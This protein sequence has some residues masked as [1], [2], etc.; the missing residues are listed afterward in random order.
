VADALTAPPSLAQVQAEAS[1]RELLVRPTERETRRRDYEW[2]ATVERQQRLQALAPGCG[3]AWQ[4]SRGCKLPVIP[5]D[6]VSLVPV[7]EAI[8]DPMEVLDYWS[9]PPNLAHAVGIRLG[10]H[11]GGAMAL[12]GLK[13]DTWGQWRAWLREHAVDTQLRPWSDEEERGE[14]EV[15][16]RPLGGPSLL[17]WTAP[18]GPPIKAFSSKG[19][20]QLREGAAW[21]R[22]INTPPDRGGFLAWTV[23]PADGK[24]PV[25]SVAASATAWRSSPPMMSYR[26]TRAPTAA[27][28]CASRASSARPT[29]SGIARPGC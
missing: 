14:L 9:Q 7:A 1:S 20:R 13:A 15:V 12:V 24:L 21:W 18:P 2:A 6:P 5:L 25:L 29:R 22:R 3:T 17:V 8:S 26:C 19:D 23:A 28:C 11:R 27:G 4:Y 16:G 10:V